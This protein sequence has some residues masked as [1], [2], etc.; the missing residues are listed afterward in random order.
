MFLLHSVTSKTCLIA[1]RVGA[2]VCLAFACYGRLVAG[3]L[4]RTV[5]RGSE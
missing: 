3:M 5:Q 4:H 1:A 2:L